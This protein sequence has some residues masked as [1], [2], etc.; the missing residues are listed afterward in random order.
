MRTLKLMN[1]FVLLTSLIAFSAMAADSTPEKEQMPAQQSSKLESINNAPGAEHDEDNCPMKHDEKNCPMHKGKKH[2]KEKHG[3]P[4]KY[5]HN[6]NNA[7]D[8][9]DHEQHNDKAHP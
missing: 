4:C 9:C 5:E 1:S 3:E 7:K 8:K 2:C 6:K